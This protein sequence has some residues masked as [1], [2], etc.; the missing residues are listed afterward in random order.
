MT[1]ESISAIG[2]PMLMTPAATR[3]RLH[4]QRRR[5]GLRL[6]EI[7]TLVSKGYLEA[8]LRHDPAALEAAANAFISDALFGVS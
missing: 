8:E 7:E 2:R 3:M 6:T 1:T 5:K 4:R